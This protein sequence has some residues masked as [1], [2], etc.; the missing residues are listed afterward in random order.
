MVEMIDNETIKIEEFNGW[1]Q[2]SIFR[3]S[4]ILNLK[5]D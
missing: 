4:H 5:N 2:I 1:S 3:L